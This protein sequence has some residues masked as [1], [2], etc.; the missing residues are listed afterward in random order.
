MLCALAG[1]ADCGLVTVVQAQANASA[2]N[3][4][5]PPTPPRVLSLPAVPVAPDAQLPE[6][7]RVE[8]QV[9]VKSDGTGA[10]ERCTESEA[11]CERVRD[12]MLQARFEPARRN[13][14]AIA[15]RVALVLVL[16][17]DAEN[18]SAPAP[19]SAQAGDASAAA[20]PVAPAPESEASAEFGATGRVRAIQQPGMRR[21]ELA[22]TRD[23]PGAFG[24]PFRAV[25]V[26]PG[27]VPVLS[28]LPYFYVRGA[29]PAGTLYIYDD[30]PVPTL[31]HLAI[32]P[33][34]I[35][36]RMVGPI[37]LYS[38]VAPARYGRLTG[39]VVVGEG[40]DVPDGRTHAEMELRLLDVS[41]YLQAPALGGTVTGA[42]RYGYPGLL[43]S[44]FSPTVGLAYW[45]Y[46][47]RYTGDTSAR[48]RFDLVALGSY[49]SVGFSDRP[50]D[51][52]TIS[53]HRLEPR[54]IVRR[55]AT[56]YGVAMMLGFDESSLSSRFRLQA[57]RFG[58]RAW[59]EHR[60]SAN[61]RLRLSGDATGV[62]GFFHSDMQDPQRRDSQVRNKLIGDVPARSLWGL[63]AELGLRPLPALE[64]QLGAR[65]DAWVQGSGAEAV[66]DPRARVVVHA[67]PEFD[68]HVA[69]GVVHQPAVFYIPLPGIV[70]VATDNGLQTAIQSEAGIGWDTPI[71]LRAE[72]QVFLHHYDNLVFTD[73]IALRD[74]FAT[75]CA[76]IACNGVSVPDRTGGYSYGLEFFL[77]RPFT[78]R[79][80]GVVSYTLAWS[81]V[82][83]VAKLAYTPSWDVRHVTNVVAQWDM[84]G[85]FSSGARFSL[86]SGKLQG[87]FVIDDS[88][89]L[90]R[91]ERRMPL[92]SRLDL[93][94]AY[95]WRTWWGRLRVSLEWF[96]ATLAR[97]P[98]EIVCTGQPRKC[99][100]IY[101][102]AIFL[103]NLGVRGEI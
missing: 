96:N 84:G 87:D 81:A 95:A 70:D 99:E 17:H 41:S 98:S 66:L 83:D 14:V 23:L 72:A 67:S 94:L 47:L 6:A 38:G 102:P 56:E 59:L 88:L 78:H 65:A 54:L 33:A 8:V 32:G 51:N 93:E 73:A 24:D 85:G 43:L 101:L 79:L 35:H 82:D 36:P 10:V 16:T 25:E 55:G 4:K 26:L 64:L 13:G 20:A 5:A 57:L 50:Q 46:Q 77:R 92:F 9:L 89:K 76:S 28:G 97:E 91:E 45:D 80:S 100:V 58:P 27:I 53:F 86:R 42:V 60:F 62:T 29:P 3:T 40:P 37:R 44:I 49:D 69:G 18:E 11:L 30:I 61:T 48:V 34:V 90:A 2:S 68:L 12:A 63:Q 19:A 7:G 22:E 75:I 103:P 39:G 52:V 1:V 74:S 71:D 15:S 31:Y 21:L